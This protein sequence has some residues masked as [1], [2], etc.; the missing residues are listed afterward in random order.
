MSAPRL[1]DPL[2]RMSDRDFGTPPMDEIRPAARASILREGTFWGLFA[3]V[4]I[5]LLG[6][7]FF[8]TTRQ[9][10]MFSTVSP[11]STTGMAPLNEPRPAPIMVPEQHAPPTKSAQ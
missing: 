4:A 5:L 6:A 9:D 1:R 11:T 3:V 8:Y 2:A 10:A 7:L